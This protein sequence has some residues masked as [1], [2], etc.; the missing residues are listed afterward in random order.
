VKVL[1]TEDFYNKLM[2]KV[3]VKK[4]ALSYQRRPVS[5]NVFFNELKTLMVGEAW[6]QCKADE[7]SILDEET[8]NACHSGRDAPSKDLT[9]FPDS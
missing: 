6:R 4:G 2:R 5:G 9:L 3:K 1:L 8:L 7:A